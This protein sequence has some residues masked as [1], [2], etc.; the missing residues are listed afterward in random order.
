V[1]AAALCIP[2]SVGRLRLVGRE[3]VLGAG[4]LGLAALLR[5][6]AIGG[7][8]GF[9]W[10]EPVYTNVARHVSQFGTIQ[11]KQPVGAV[12]QPYLFHPPFYFLLLGLW[13]RISSSSIAHAR[14]LAA[15]AS[16]VVLALLWGLLRD[17][18]GWRAL[19]PVALVATDGWMVYENRVGWIENTM[20]VLGVAAYW[21]YARAVRSDSARLYLVAGT[22]LGL[23]GIMKHVGLYLVGAVLVHW[24]VTRGSRRQHL[25]LL[26]AVAAVCTAY[27][28]VMTLVYQGAHGNWFLHDSTV[29]FER[30][31]GHHERRGTVNSLSN[32]IGPIFDQYKIFYSTLAV[33]FAGVALVGYR[34]VQ[35]IATRSLARIQQHALLFSWA[36]ASIVVFGS[37]KLRFPHYALMLLI[38]LYAYLAEESFGFART[39]RRRWLV[40]IGIG[41]LL[42]ANA[43][44]YM[45]RFVSKDDNAL[46]SVA[47]YVAANVPRSAVVVTEEP[48]GVLI[49]Q[50]YC[51][52]VETASC[53]RSARYVVLYRSH[54]QEPPT[55]ASLEQKM[56][57]ARVLATFVGF[58]EQ[59]TV[60]RVRALRKGGT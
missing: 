33:F 24:F 35:A 41:M 12:A 40:G 50:S 23:T 2:R 59:I 17:Q 28:V 3:A 55:N 32:V 19:V 43:V 5:F 25:A 48:I 45:Q 38:P 60:Y 13:F 16:I 58:K 18:I 8:P 37:I 44:T 22:L 14:E 36:F 1:T 20:L 9:E 49:P 29:Q 31:L 34:L 46:G 56:A 57:G 53:G 6:W 11:L 30:T 26:G 47:A 21:T 10:D 27:V 15:G 39:S 42:T 7:R 51:K 52:L 4:L 54:T